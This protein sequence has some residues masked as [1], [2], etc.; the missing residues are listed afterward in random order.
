MFVGMYDVRTMFVLTL[1]IPD[2]QCMEYL[3][4]LHL[5]EIYGTM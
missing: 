3:L 4:Y 1:Q 5:A 2:A